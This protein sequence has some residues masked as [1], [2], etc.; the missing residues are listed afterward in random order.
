[1]TLAEKSGKI[2]QWAK[3]LGFAAC[4]ITRVREAQEQREHLLQWLENNYHGTMA[5]MARNV[6]KRLNPAQLVPGARSIIVVLM[7]YLPANDLN[8]QKYKISRYAWGMDYHFVIKKRLRQLLGRMQQQWGQVQ[9]R[10]FTDSAPV[11]E[12]FWAQQAGLGWIG[13]NSLLLTKKGSYFFIGELIV[14]IELEYDRPWEKNF[15]GTCTRCMDACPTGAIVQPQVVDARRCLSYL[16]IEYRGDFTDQTQLH[17]WVFGCDICQQVCPWNRHA[18]PTQIEELR[19]RPDLLNLTDEQ[20][21]NLTKQEF[22]QIFRRTPVER[23]GFKGLVRNVRQNQKTALEK[24]NN[25]DQIA[26]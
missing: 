6:D 15:C 12:R 9:G 26:R 21:E 7:D 10:A 19:P 8:L 23:T 18:Q 16:T 17:G 22:K 11:L 14:D 1:M 24:N 3:E 4:G 5:Y 25:R 2:K 20:L 13:K